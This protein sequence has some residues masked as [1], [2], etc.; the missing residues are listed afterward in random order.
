MTGVADG[1]GEADGLGEALGDGLGDALGEGLGDGVG[2]GDGASTVI[3]PIIPQQPPCG[4]QKYGK[5]P[6]LKNVCENVSFL[7][8]IPESQ[9]PSGAPGVPEVVLWMLEPHVH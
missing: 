3:E 8:L 1:V 6:A 4:V 9:I 2:V 7:F 5:K